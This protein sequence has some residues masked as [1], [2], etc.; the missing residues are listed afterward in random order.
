MSPLRGR[1]ILTL[2]VRKFQPGNYLGNLLELHVTFGPK[3]VTDLLHP[4]RPSLGRRR[5]HDILRTGCVGETLQS[6]FLRLK[7]RETDAVSLTAQTIAA[8]SV[9]SE[10]S[11]GIPERGPPVGGSELIDGR[12][13]AGS[14]R[15]G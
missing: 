15:R 8:D 2:I 1:H 7:A 13:E 14:S 3:L 12:R 5:N 10:A 11:N 6:S 4:C 9:V